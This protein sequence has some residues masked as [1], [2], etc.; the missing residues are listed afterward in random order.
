MPKTHFRDKIHTNMATTFNDVLLLPGFTTVEPEEVNISTKFTKEIILKTP[1]V[2]SPMDTVTE[3]A[4]AI[5]IAR[6]G[7]LGFIHRNCNIETQVEMVKRVKKA[8]S[9]IITDVITISKDQT[10]ANAIKVMHEKN[11]NGLPVVEKDLLIGI[12]TGRDVRFAEET[13][14]LLV[15]DVM[16][17]DLVTAS[18]NIS[19][20]EAIKL[21]HKHRI[22]KLPVTDA[23]QLIGLITVK[24]LMLK[25]KFP[26]ASRD[27][28]GSL[29]CGAAI[30]PFDYDRAIALDKNAD[31][32]VT[33]VSHFHNENCFSA[34]KKLLKKGSPD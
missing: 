8:E 24:D 15:K 28:D 2:S 17:K 33:D 27:K 26:D 31:I 34:T 13:E 9:F 3:S 32:L 23:G 22:E 12:V 20:E 14:K 21:L 11:I 1:F 7:G 4:M 30:S 25:G 29:L 5:A 18:K 16:T 10:V 6:Q 19:I